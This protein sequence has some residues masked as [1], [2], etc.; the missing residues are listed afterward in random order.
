MRFE[1]AKI[2]EATI[3]EPGAEVGFRYHPQAVQRGS[4]RMASF[5]AGR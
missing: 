5:A 3:V 2:G 4:A 1:N